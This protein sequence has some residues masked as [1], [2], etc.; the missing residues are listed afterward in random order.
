MSEAP[1]E[2]DIRRSTFMSTRA[3]A[4]MCFTESCVD[5]G[6]LK[7]P[8]ACPFQEQPNESDRSRG[9][10]TKKGLPGR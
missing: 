8:H 7:S 4:A 3:S 10:N 2:A 5:L 1:P 6:H 9:E